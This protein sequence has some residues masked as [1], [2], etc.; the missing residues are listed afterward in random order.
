[1]DGTA[2]I[3]KQIGGIGYYAMVTVSCTSADDS[4]VEV[5]VSP[6]AEDTF[7]RR[8]G[9]LEAARFGALTGMK[10]S[11]RSCNCSVV[12]IRGHIVDTTPTL[13][14]LA[15]IMAVWS[16]VSFVPSAGMQKAIEET[17][18][19]C[20]KIPVEQLEKELRRRACT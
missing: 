1:M 14:A 3:A 11:E 18:L 16:A 15:A 8:E 12:Q 20:R 2:K 17:V 6:E 10:L 7:A 5:T 9:W 4:A 19:L 13:V